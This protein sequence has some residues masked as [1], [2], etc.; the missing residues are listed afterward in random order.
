[1]FVPSNTNIMEKELTPE[2]SLATIEQM[3]ADA[4]RSFHRN[5][6]YFLLWGT[7][8]IAAMIFNYAMAVAHNPMGS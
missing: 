7:L 1:M 8:L 5:S 6:F 3:I 2:Q 4:K